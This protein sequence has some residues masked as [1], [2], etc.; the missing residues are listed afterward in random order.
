MTDREQATRLE[1]SRNKVKNGFKALPNAARDAEC[2]YIR[3][4]VRG[5][6]TRSLR[7]RRPV[8]VLNLPLS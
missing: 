2:C 8:G 1:L 6:V 5:Q 3:L 4:H 7:R